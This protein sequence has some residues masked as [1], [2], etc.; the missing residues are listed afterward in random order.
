MNLQESMGFIFTTTLVLPIIFIIAFRLYRYRSF[1]A[2]GIFYL[3]AFFDAMMM[4]KYIPA[5]TEFRRIFGI[6]T[7]LLDVPLLLT[8]FSYFS[9]SSACTRRMKYA[10]IFFVAFEIIIMSIY[11]FNRSALTIIIAPGLAI[12]LFFCACFFIRQIKIA[13]MYRKAIGK[14]LMTSSFL[15]VFGC[16]SLIYVMYYIIRT[17]HT[18]DVYIMYLISSALSVIVVSAGIIIETRRLRKLQELQITR[19]ELSRI[20]ADDKIGK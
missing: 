2:L 4:Q 8:F 3:L 11:G 20:Y 6:T 12:I 19:R 14:A 5:G 10:M 13:I 7:N 1:L 17:P 15:F 9:P 16:Y 18:K